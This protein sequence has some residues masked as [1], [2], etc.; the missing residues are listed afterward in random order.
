MTRISE[1]SGFFSPAQQVL[2]DSGTSIKKFKEVAGERVN[3][4]YVIVKLR[5]YLHIP[6]NFILIKK[7]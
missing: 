2:K 5:L 7:N 3:N 4:V 6:C 1:K